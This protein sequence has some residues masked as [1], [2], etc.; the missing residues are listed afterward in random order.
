MQFSIKKLSKEEYKGWKLP[1]QYSSDG[2]YDVHINKSSE[3][4]RVEIIRTVLEETVIHLM[5]DENSDALFQDH[6]ENTYA[7]GIFDEQRL[8]GVLETD[9]EI[10]SNRLR[11]TELWVDEAYR[12]KGLAHRLMK[13]AKEQARQERRRAII[14]ETQ[15]CNVNA[16]SFYHSEGFE[17]IGFDR[18]CYS[19]D[20]LEKKEVRL[21]FGFL[22]DHKSRIQE[23]QLVIRKE[24]RE[25]EKQVERMTQL[26]F[27]NKH[28]QGC[29]EHYLVHKLR[30]DPA[31]LSD[32]SRIACV[33]EDIVGCIMYSKAKIIE[34]AQTEHTVLTFGP[35]CVAPDWQGRGIGELLLKE[36]IK[37]AAEQGYPGI[38][39]FG[40]PDYYPRNG[41]QTCDRFHITT[42]D[43]KNFDAFMAY[44]LNEDG[45][46]NI[47]GRFQESEVFHKL[48]EEEVSEFNLRF[49]ILEKIPFPFHWD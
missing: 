23:E 32:I 25:D 2:Y 40:E 17:L 34:N 15:S 28:H 1:M 38:V 16:I 36:T 12:R 43:G 18:S 3:G 8:V 30:K 31:Y 5:K 21:E 6:W 4:Y 44:E 22:M 9:V 20:D 11:I 27:W 33:G 46:K 19:N 47:R 29:D 35:L 41:F 14:L 13:I 26:A 37:L 7:W 49:P 24:E 39:I 10:W 42:M 45:F 48:P